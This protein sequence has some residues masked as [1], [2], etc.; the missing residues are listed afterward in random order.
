MEE[1]D[2]TAKMK[3]ITSKIKN[4]FGSSP[5]GPSLSLYLHTLRFSV[6][7]SMEI[8]KCNLFWIVNVKY[9]VYD[10][11]QEVVQKKTL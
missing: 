3:N 6:G 1:G 2:S 8:S 4:F 10:Y 9:Q 7:K 11:V 5:L